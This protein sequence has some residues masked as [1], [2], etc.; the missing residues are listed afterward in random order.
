MNGHKE[1]QPP[2]ASTRKSQCKSNEDKV[3]PKIKYINKIFKKDA[4][5]V[6]KAIFPVNATLKKKLNQS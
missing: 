5:K 4:H 3:K 2:L 6:P 1:E